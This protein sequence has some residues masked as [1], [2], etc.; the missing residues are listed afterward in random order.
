MENMV[1]NRIMNLDKEYVN[2]Q[3]SVKTMLKQVALKA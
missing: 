1:K 3:L 2:Y